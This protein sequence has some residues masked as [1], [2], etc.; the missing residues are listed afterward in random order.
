MKADYY[1]RVNPDLLKLI[2]PDAKVVLEIGCG[3]GALAE[4]YQRIN[5]EIE[6]YGIEVNEEAANMASLTGVEIYKGCVERIVRADLDII[7]DIDAVVFGDV[8]EHL[9][10]PWAVLKEFT[11]DLIPGAQILAS[12]PNIQHFSVLYSLLF[13][14]FKYTD[15]GVMDRTHLRWFTLGS[16]REMFDQAELQI[17]EVRGIRSPACEEGW[18]LWSEFIAP[19]NIDIRQ[20][21]PLQYLVRAIKPTPRELFAMPNLDSEIRPIHIHAVKAEECC[22]RPRI[23][24]PFEALSTIPG[25]K[26]TVGYNLDTVNPDIHIQQRARDTSMALQRTLVKSGTLLIAELD[27]DPVGLQGYPE[28]DYMQLRA[29][30]AVQVSTEQMAKTVREWNPNVMVFENQ[31]ADLPPMREFKDGPVRIFYGAQ[32]R[33]DD[34]APIMPALNQVLADHPDIFVEVV[35]DQ[36]FYFALNVSDSRKRFHT[37]LPYNQYRKLLRTCDIALLPLEPTPFNMHKS[38]IKFL[39]CAAEGTIAFMSET[40]VKQVRCSHACYA[41]YTHK[42]GAFEEIFRRVINEHEALQRIRKAAYTYIRDHRMLGQHFR[43]RL[44]WYRGLLQSKEDLDRQLFERV[45]EL[46]YVQ[47]APSMSHP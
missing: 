36:E 33:Q 44:S 43:K 7:D 3:A 5:P 9:H 1:S 32:H 45:P 46:Q 40:A 17:H 35:C 13:G 28:N 27:D 26:C 31:I 25:V 16:I 6:W 37:F 47:L 20:T 19:L 11:R 4:A 2:P 29:V 21:A 12:I 8:L 14:H 38:D 22:A 10:D 39:E 42:P 24:E 23:Y 30:H 18:K 41:W 15:E 34:W